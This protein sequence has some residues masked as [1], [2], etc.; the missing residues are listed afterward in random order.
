MTRWLWK[1]VFRTFKMWSIKVMS[2]CEDE[3]EVKP[4]N[5]SLFQSK[6]IRINI[7]LNVHWSGYLFVTSILLCMIFFFCM[8]YSICMC[9]LR[10]VIGGID[11]WPALMWIDRSCLIWRKGEGEC[12]H[13]PTLLCLC[14]IQSCIYSFAVFL[15]KR[16]SITS[17]IDVRPVFALLW[18]AQI[19]LSL[20]PLR[21]SCF[22]PPS[23][24]LSQTVTGGG[25]ALHFNASLLHSLSFPVRH[26]MDR[27]PRGSPWISCFRVWSKTTWLLETLWFFFTRLKLSGGKEFTFRV[28][29]VGQGVSTHSHIHTD[30]MQSK[31]SRQIGLC[32]G[33][34]MLSY[35][36]SHQCLWLLSPVS[37][38]NI[39]WLCLL[40]WRSE[41]HTVSQPYN[42]KL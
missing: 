37:T 39:T 19:Y 36:F 17:L 35:R 14:S 18:L 34:N 11:R 25:C 38:W 31:A 16:S 40:S 28:V 8:C 5:E 29:D 4:H 32:W 42:G 7:L 13:C 21:S 30:N 27:V 9:V 26:Q 23:S 24:S 3:D 1:Q 6:S 22:H 15:P 12:W 41:F 33:N 2:A 20:S 10:G